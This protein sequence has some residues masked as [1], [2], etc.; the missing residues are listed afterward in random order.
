MKNIILIF[1]TTFSLA[2][3]GQNDSYMKE[4]AEKQVNK[5]A[6]QME[7]T[8]VEKEAIY[9]ECLT[10]QTKTSQLRDKGRKMSEKEFNDQMIK[11]RKNFYEAVS[12]IFTDQ[13]KKGEWQE[14]NRNLY[15][16]K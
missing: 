13:K 8:Q 4:R 14:M 10:F 6:N 1:F 16:K 11:E 2:C 9:N 3:I 15:V 12:K 7:L 5:I